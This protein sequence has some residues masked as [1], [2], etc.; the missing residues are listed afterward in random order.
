VPTYRCFCITADNQTVTGAQIT[1]DSL[2]S[3]VEAANKLWQTVPEYRLVEVW[4]GRDARLVWRFDR[5]NRG[6]LPDGPIFPA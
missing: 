2:L 1:A 6:R 5:W 4:Q 3:A